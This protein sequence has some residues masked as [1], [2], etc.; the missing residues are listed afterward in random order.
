MAINRHDAR[1]AVF[2]LLFETEFK[3]DE[4]KE[5]IFALSS[6]NRDIE[7]DAYIRDTYFGVCERIEEL[8]E[9]IS[10]HAKGWKTNRSSRISR[11]ILRLCT[12]EM[13]YCDDIPAAVSINEGIELCKRFDRE[14][15]RSF[16]NG[17]LNGI[18]DE[19]N[20]RDNG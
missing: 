13:L 7:E 3:N 16:L 19:I 12:Y 17:V 4:A 6:E 2:A 15:A 10:R 18:K 5:D 20:A 1:E 14:E 8:D 11:S 9:L